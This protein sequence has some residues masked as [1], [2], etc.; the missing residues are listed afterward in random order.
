MLLF[1]YERRLLAAR[2]FVL[3][4]HEMPVTEQNEPETGQPEWDWSQSCADLAGR[5]YRCPV[6]ILIADGSGDFQTTEE[7]VLHK[8]ILINIGDMNAHPNC[9]DVEYPE[10]DP[11]LS[12][13]ISKEL[14]SRLIDIIQT[15]ELKHPGNGGIRGTVA[16]WLCM[17]CGI[18]TLGRCCVH[19]FVFTHFVLLLYDDV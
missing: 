16:A 9:R 4:M 5:I 10:Y 19:F 1:L 11:K 17:C 13:Y 3:Q 6:P 18:C 7:Q 2:H 12:N 15:A 8:Q 14:Y